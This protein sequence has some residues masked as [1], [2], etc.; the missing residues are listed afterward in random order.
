MVAIAE[1]A[2]GVARGD[3][4]V[5]WEPHAGFQ[6]KA[7][8]ANADEL[9][10][11]GAKGCGKGDLLTTG[12]LR[13]TDREAFAGLFLRDSYRQLL[14]QIDR[15]HQIYDRLAA[16]RRPAW[17]GEK[18]R[19]VWPS[20][21][22]VQYGHCRTLDDVEAYQGGNWARIS[23]DEVANQADERVIDQLI[24]ELRCA[25][26][27]I[28]RQFVGSGNP[29]FA[30]HAWAK[31]RYVTPCGKDGSKI[32]WTKLTLPDG[33]V[34]YWSRQFVPGRVT[35]NPIYA[36]DPTYLAQLMLLPERMRKGLLEGDWDASSGAALDEIDADAHLVQP[37]AC[38]D[39]WPYIA[40]FDWGYDHYAVF[41]WGRVSDDGRIYICDT[42]KRRLLHDWDL[43][44]T[45]KSLV[46]TPALHLVHAGHDC[47]HIHKAHTEKAPPTKA[48]Y[49]GESGIHLV[50]ATLDRPQ[51][52]STLL[53]YLA[54]RE[55]E[56]LP[57]RVPMLQF[58]D[59][60]VNRW[61]VETHLPGMVC[62]PDD[63]RD[64]LKVDT[65]RETGMGGDDGYDCLRYLV[66]SRPL[67]ALSGV[68]L[69]KRTAFDPEVLRAE[70]MK[71]MQPDRDRKPRTILKGV[72]TGV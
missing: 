11:G 60:P 16:D 36:N 46:P 49:F 58:F 5:V 66:A 70:A 68:H 30:G 52:Y 21:A 39:H 28:R 69:L 8:R 24:A 33:R 67:P 51:G 10:L 72:Y 13:Y 18:Q 47:W 40:A 22:F 38:P 54:W 27:T 12:N 42:I 3:Y 14:R 48:D 34:V 25:D 61:M 56:F 17:N 53:R 15:A 43:V 31:R 9:F 62:D 6:T 45:Y 35:D 26:R 55:S 44:G 37:F 57:A 63:P 59:T 23:Y 1:G 32:S 19:F 65:D 7:T 2:S 71:L 4:E 64:V 41:M 29:G 20:R 50:K